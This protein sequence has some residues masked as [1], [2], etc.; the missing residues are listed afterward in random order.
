MSNSIH[1]KQKNSQLP[2]YGTIT[3]DIG[4]PKL[5]NLGWHLYE[6]GDDS[7]HEYSGKKLDDLIDLIAIKSKNHGFVLGLEAP[8]FIP[9]RKNLYNATKARFGESPRPWSAGAG[10]QVLA[11]NLPIMTYLFDNIYQKKPDIQF[12]I[13]PKEFQSK[14]LQILIFEALV[15]G[16]DKG[17][18]HIDDAKIMNDYCKIYSQSNTLPPTILRDEPEVN[19]MNLAVCALLYCKKNDY[20]NKINTP[21]PI[22]KPQLSKE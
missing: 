10:A 16:K 17:V 22:Y 20:L 7:Y 8:L 3:I 12:C 11:I 9:V 15:S 14:P 18:S 13:S 6:P 5:G 1:Q 4:S 19:Y 21:S 2:K